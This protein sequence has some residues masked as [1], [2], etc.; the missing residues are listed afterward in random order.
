MLMFGSFAFGQT[1][2]GGEEYSIEVPASVKSKYSESDV[3]KNPK[4]FNIVSDKGLTI[5]FDQLNKIVSIKASREVYNAYQ[6][7]GYNPFDEEVNS[8]TGKAS[9][10]SKCMNAPTGV[11]VGSCWLDC[12]LTTLGL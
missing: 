6:K 2:T 8:T 11:G 4:I 12:I 5:T 7:L 3:V 10:R 1:K 9:C